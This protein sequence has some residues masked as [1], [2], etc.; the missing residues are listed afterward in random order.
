MIFGEEARD[1]RRTI[2]KATYIAVSLIAVFYAFSTW[3]IAFHY[4]PSNI[5]AE[6]NAHTTTIYIS[7]IRTLL[8][9]VLALIMNALLLTSI[10]ACALSFHNTINRY[11]YAIGHEGLMWS[12]LA[13]TNGYHG[14][15]HVAG[16]IQTALA[17]GVT[18]VFAITRHDPYAVV[19]AWMGTF[20]SLGIS[21][22]QV[23]VSIAAIVF[24]RKDPRGLGIFHRLIAPGLSALG[25][26]ACLVVMAVNLA[27]VSGSDSLVVDCFPAIQA[28]IG[29]AGLAS[30]SGPDSVVP[31]SMR[32]SV[33][34]LNERLRTS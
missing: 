1:P 23:I 9:P 14:A 26:G 28:A 13:R 20:S 18:A 29:A 24:F 32:I 27:V 31:R 19:V 4:G 33:A 25:L 3:V 10:F 21:V 15:S 6:A 34:P 12:G 30:P 8:G 17:M 2:P 11:F 22:I 7:A 5:Q 16:A